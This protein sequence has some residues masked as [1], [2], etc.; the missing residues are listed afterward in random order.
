MTQ[1]G[2]SWWPEP[3]YVFSTA[4]I[5]HT[6]KGEL[7]FTKSKDRDEWI[8]GAGGEMIIPKETSLPV[9][10]QDTAIRETAEELCVTGSDRLEKGLEIT[11]LGPGPF[12]MDCRCGDHSIYKDAHGLYAFFLAILKNP[13]DKNKI[14]STK[15]PK[16]ADCETI[17]IEWLTAKKFLQQVKAGHKKTYPNIIKVLETLAWILDQYATNKNPCLTEWP[18]PIL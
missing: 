3:F 9:L 17:A 4:I 18:R 16:E 11:I 10:L 6:A 7:L 14:K 8:P 1:E 15:Q 12:Y 2:K 13:D 5:M